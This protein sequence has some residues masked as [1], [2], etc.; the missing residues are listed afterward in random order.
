MRCAEPPESPP[1]VFIH[2]RPK[3]EA[4][5]RRELAQ[6]RIDVRVELHG[7]LYRIPRGC[8]QATLVSRIHEFVFSTDAAASLTCC[9]HWIT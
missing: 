6:V 9:A 1:E 3:G 5:F 8:H 4:L 7:D 2:C